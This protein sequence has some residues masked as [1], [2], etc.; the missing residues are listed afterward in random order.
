MS[1]N[2]QCPGPGDDGLRHDGKF[3]MDPL[4]VGTVLNRS[5][6]RSNMSRGRLTFVALREGFVLPCLNHH[7]PI[8]TASLLHR[9]DPQVS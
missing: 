1:Y 7:K 2:I 5:Q 8:A 9:F 3:M 6:R 4:I